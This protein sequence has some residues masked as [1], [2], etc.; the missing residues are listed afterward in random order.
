MTTAHT[1]PAISQVDVR[2][3][4]FSAW[5]TTTVLIIT[6]AVSAVSPAAAA[7]ILGLQA[8]VFAIGALLGPHRAPY[9]TIFRTLIQPRLS[10]VTER[11]PVPP[12]QFA[13]LLGFTFAAIGTIGF[14]TGVTLPGVIATALALGAAFLNAAFGICLGC[15]I[16]P[17]IT[18]LRRTQP[19]AQ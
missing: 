17:L 18:R 11:E 2:G 14:A 7:V 19:S 4:R 10:P 5:V 1:T 9:G 12:L 3:P 8:V 15:Q 6:L 13:Q 16:Y